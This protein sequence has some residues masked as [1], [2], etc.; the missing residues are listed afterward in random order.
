MTPVASVIMPAFNCGPFIAKA[1]DSILQ[2]T[3][4]DL[5][6]LICD[7][8]ST[9]DT[10]Q[11]IDSFTDPRIRKFRHAT[12]VGLL[13]NFNFLLE[14]TRGSFVTCQDADDWSE[15]TRL[16]EQLAAF[17][18]H[19]EVHLVGCN[20]VFYYND[21]N[22]R[23]CPAFESGYVTAE[24]EVQPFILPAILYRREVLATVGGFHP[25]FEKATSMDQ[26][27]IFNILSAFKGYAINRYLY[28]ARFNPGSN[29]RNLDNFR[30]A[31]AHE[32][33]LLL[34]RQRLETGS[35]WIMEGKESKLLEFET[36]LFQR[37]SFRAEKYREYAVYRVDS[38]QPIEA[39]RLLTLAFVTNPLNLDLYRTSFYAI[40][41]FL[42]RSKR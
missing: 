17:K 32:A 6:L 28:T 22:I 23:P 3:A 36:A 37:R 34:R 1:I 11:V 7:D 35:D 20:G 42:F 27:F 30:K 29:T 8:A 26:Y 18:L 39:L 5:E 13:K 12:N 38:D 2:Q 24:R 21:E 31:T 19:P 25:Y 40:R 10:W 4:S 15:P 9:D 33:Y 14:Q 16:E 41:K